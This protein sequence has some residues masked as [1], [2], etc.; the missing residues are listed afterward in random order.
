MRNKQRLTS[1][2]DPLSAGREG[3]PGG[4][5]SGFWLPL[6]S[7]RGD[8]GGEVSSALRRAIRAAGLF[9]LLVALYFT[10]YSGQP[11]SSDELVLFDAAHSLV[12]YGTLELAYS[13]DQRPYMHQPEPDIALS[14][15][16]E[17]MQ[18]YAAA[19]LLWVA[20][21]V[22]GLG[23][24]QTVWLLNILVTAL[25]AVVLYYYGI[26]LGY[27]DRAALAVAL[28]FGAATIAWPYSRMFFREPLFTLL[29]LTCAY[30]L[31][32]WRRQLDVSRFYLGWLVGALLALTGALFTKEASLLLVPTLVLVALPGAVR[33]LFN[34]R[35]LFTL[36]VL[37]A[38]IVV[39]V[40][41]Y[42]QLFPS[43]RFS[44]LMDRVSHI[45]LTYLTVAL[46]AY[47]FSPGASLWAFSP[48][49]LL[50]WA[51]AY[52]LAR[53]RAARQ[54]LIPLV[55]LLSITVGYSIL[56]G[57]NWYSGK[58]WGPRYLVPI[59][60]FLALWLL[61][62]ATTLLN[63]RVAVWKQAI[64]VGLTAQSFLI[65]IIALTVPI[66]A[67][68]NYLYNESVALNRLDRLIV[69]W[70]EGTWNPLY[71]PPVVNAHQY[72][73]PSPIAWIVTHSGALVMP[74]CLLTAG[75]SVWAITRRH[76]SRRAS[77]LAV[78]A[79][80]VSLVIMLYGGLRAFYTDVRMG[81]SNP[82]LFE[83]LD[84]IDAG[85]RPGD[86][87]LLNDA[88]FRLIFMN[89]Y[90]R[91]EPAYLMPVAPGERLDLDQPPE[92]VTNNPEDRPHPIISE[93]LARLAQTTS[94]WWF[95]T[96]FGPF[97]KGR[98]RPIEQYLVRH[99]FPVDE[100]YSDPNVARLLRFAPIS[101]PPDRVPPWPQYPV[102]ANFGAA[103]LV[104]F[105]LP[106]GTT[107]KRGMMLPVALLWRHEGWGDVPPFDYSINVSL[108]NKEG[109]AVAQRAQ[110]PLATFGPMSQWVDGGYYHDNHALEV[111]A[112]LPPGDYELWVLIFDWRDGHRLPVRSA[113]GATGDHV[114]IATIRVTS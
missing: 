62:V 44:N 73:A 102:N 3:E 66:E 17:P 40:T 57:P 50:G 96:E 92:I 60:P 72:A 2:P 55:M 76:M 53:R 98:L 11:N 26:A 4:A 15:D 99:Y 70:Q 5:D 82:A 95:V 42:R 63:R 83:M 46:P 75:T 108:I 71:I 100:V 81:G 54:V 64:A 59:T 68:G 38:L 24:V 28:I 90:K 86:A 49:L 109:A 51:G 93:M 45:D 9:G 37:I 33:R 20:L 41:L 23:L 67:F 39:S 19:P 1:P 87:V 94:R 80:A 105:D 103:T 31:E 111:P 58:G 89:Y 14:L 107:I 77:G 52:S 84:R 85:L 61:P 69:P 104:G 12:Q 35:T 79:M 91:P 113:T 48:V 97:S 47:L 114:M 21:H 34:R 110:P 43:G 88:S 112:N 65:Q 13:S 25:T 101:A 106:R 32:R 78:S 22:P 8:W 6:S 18:V 36:A 7:W 10:T 30:C 74:L 16:I 56:Q 29:A 27:T